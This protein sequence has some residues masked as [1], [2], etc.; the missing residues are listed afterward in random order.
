MRYNE[1][2]INAP[3]VG[4]ILCLEF[5]DTLIE[6][7][8]TDIR[9]DGVVVS[10]DK[11][12]VALINEAVG[13]RNPDPNRP[14]YYYGD[15]EEILKA[16]QKDTPDQPQTPPQAKVG[17]DRLRNLTSLNQENL[18]NAF[19]WCMDYFR[20][21]PV[22]VRSVLATLKNDSL[23]EYLKDAAKKSNAFSKF[24]FDERDLVDSQDLLSEFYKDPLVNTWADVLARFKSSVVTTN[25][26]E[27]QGRKVPLGK[28]MKG[29]VKKSKVYVKGPS[30]KVV[31]VNFGD[32]N[33]RIKKS[34]PKHR[35]S[36]RARHNCDN[37]GPRWKARYWSCKAW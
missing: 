4:D 13:M 24:K 1:F 27:Y 15:P 16:I 17:L 3:Q 22:E 35:K 32:P 19:N 28:P 25:E 33:M 12:A 9:S 18:D 29:D 14:S 8:I 34:S 23:I 5:G 7:V 31:K 26:A 2:T 37:P 20:R 10:L 30:G 36:F 11:N 21:M 6:S